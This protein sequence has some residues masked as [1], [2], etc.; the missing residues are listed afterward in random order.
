MRGTKVDMIKRLDEHDVS[1][2]W[3]QEI[4]Y[5]GTDDET[6]AKAFGEQMT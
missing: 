2:T 1:G 4:K 3:R 5:L 6:I